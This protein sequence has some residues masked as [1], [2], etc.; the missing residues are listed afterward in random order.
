M[1]VAVAVAHPVFGFESVN[2]RYP[3]SLLAF[4]SFPHIVPELYLLPRC[5]REATGPGFTNRV[6]TYLAALALHNGVG[7]IG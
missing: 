5:C 7:Q 2:D 4:G 6:G 3:F 1:P